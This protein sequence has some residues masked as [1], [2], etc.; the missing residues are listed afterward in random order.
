MES[1]A[2]FAGARPGSD[3]AWSH[4]AYD[5]GRAL[6]GRG[7]RLVYGAGGLGLMGEVSTGVLDAGG[8]V[9]GVIPDFMVEREWGRQDLTELVTVD[10]M[11][12]RKA[13][14][15][16]RSDAVLV[17]PGGL[18]TLEELV[19]IWSWQNLEVVRKPI[20]L[21]DLA[22]FWDPLLALA[23]HMVDTGFMAATAREGL[24]VRPTIDTAL[25]ALIE[26]L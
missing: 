2:V 25:D 8:E 19:E 24:M 13:L 22:G 5:L 18:G 12:T 15:Y 4:A 3:P 9:V 21:L 16:Q 23:D 26:A 20:C 6:A 11:H 1:I 17:L 10:S 7:I 14:M